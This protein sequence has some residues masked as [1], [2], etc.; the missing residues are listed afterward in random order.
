MTCD[1]GVRGMCCD[2]TLGVKRGVAL[3]TVDNTRDSTN[4]NVLENN[5]N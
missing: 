2:V 4:R 3:C 1:V 5:F